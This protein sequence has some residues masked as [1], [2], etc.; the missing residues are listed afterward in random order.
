MAHRVTYPHLQ[1][2][3]AVSWIWDSA[4]DNLQLCDWYESSKY[5]AA[6]CGAFYGGCQGASLTRP[7]DANNCYPYAAWSS[8][9]AT[10]SGYYYVYDYKN[11]SFFNPFGTPGHVSTFAVS[12]RCVLD[13]LIVFQYI[14][15]IQTPGLQL[16]EWYE[17]SKYG[18]TRCLEYNGGCQGAAH[19]LAHAGN[20][21]PRSIWSSSISPSYG[22]FV[23][24]S[25]F[26]RQGSLVDDYC[27]SSESGCSGL[28]AFSVRC[29][30]DLATKYRRYSSVMG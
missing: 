15:K 19:Q 25:G 10:S 5:G 30:P 2:L 14:Y 4:A 11:G 8:S 18:A 20:C 23:F 6:Q 29:V 17:S 7:G 24:H 1:S 27:Y 21:Y 3:C 28:L 16:C 26:L 9:P 12:V 22:S 13:L